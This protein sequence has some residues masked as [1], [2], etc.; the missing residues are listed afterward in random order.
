[1]DISS[2][3]ILQFY[4][5]HVRSTTAGGAR[6]RGNRA[7]VAARAKPARLPGGGKGPR[8]TTQYVDIIHGVTGKFLIA[9]ALAAV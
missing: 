2:H 8:L 5:K 4:S 3:P 6:W 1:M 9:W 7:A